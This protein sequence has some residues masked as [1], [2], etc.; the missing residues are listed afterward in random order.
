MTKPRKP[1]PL[2]SE[3]KNVQALVEKITFDLCKRLLA[4]RKSVPE[5]T[6]LLRVEKLKSL[7][8]VLIPTIN[9]GILQ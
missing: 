2:A 3:L 8:Y 9:F 5:V 4:H 6:V 1:I 7:I